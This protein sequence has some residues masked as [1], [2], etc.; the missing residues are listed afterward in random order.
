MGAERSILIFGAGSVGGYLGGK[1]AAITSL[2]LTLLGRPRL[3]KAIQGRG[4]IVR[5]AGVES[6]SHPQAESA[7]VDGCSFDLVM[8]TVR[9]YD[10]AGALPDVKRALGETGLVLAMQNGI[11]TE[12]D[13]ADS[14]GQDRLVAGTLTVRPGMDE[15]GVVT[16]YSRSGGVA[17][18]GMSSSPVPAWIVEAFRATGLPTV[19]IDDYRSLRWSKLL[20]NMLGAATSAILD[21]D[22][23]ELVANSQLFRLEQLAFREAGRVMDAQGIKTVA[24]PGYPVPLGRVVMRLP[25]PLAQRLIG[26]RMSRARGGHSPGMR[27]DLKRGKTEI[28]SYNGAIARAAHALGLRAPVNAAL[29]SL[30]HELTQHI[31][32]RQAFRG[33]IPEFLTYMRSHG[34]RI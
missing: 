24:L 28:D 22:V 27:G 31:D 16:R 20:L 5:E 2:R 3:V 17:L 11:G 7:I 8:L 19:L 26:P 6:V 15:P 23:Q 14:L 34:V 18:A 33:N 29:T 4:L 10:V 32:R 21:I 30:T 13:L 9:T 25:R 12:E 1:L